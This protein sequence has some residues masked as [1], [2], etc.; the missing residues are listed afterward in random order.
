MFCM[1]ENLKINQDLFVRINSFN[2]TS[3]AV[4]HMQGNVLRFLEIV[5]IRKIVYSEIYGIHPI[6]M[7]M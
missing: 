7:S 3:V 4:K 1:I 5:T 6:V 2:S